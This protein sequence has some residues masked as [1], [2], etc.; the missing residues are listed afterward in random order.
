MWMKIQNFPVHNMYFNISQCKIFH[1]KGDVK[2]YLQ[3]C[4]PEKESFRKR[5][6]PLKFVVDMAAG[7]ASLHRHGYLHQ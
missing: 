3:R 2:S 6:T 1:K 4:V 5:G 7:L